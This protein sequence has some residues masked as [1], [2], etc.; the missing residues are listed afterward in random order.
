L[1]RAAGHRGDRWL[2][3][4]FVMNPFFDPDA[5]IDLIAILVIFGVL[6]PLIYWLCG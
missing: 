5:A 1:E 2:L 4:M 3:E 6:G